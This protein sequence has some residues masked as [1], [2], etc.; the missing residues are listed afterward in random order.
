[1]TVSARKQA[2]L[3]HSLK[4]HFSLDENL[5]LCTKLKSNQFTLKGFNGSLKS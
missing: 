2:Q 5:K 4:K 1:M 3:Q